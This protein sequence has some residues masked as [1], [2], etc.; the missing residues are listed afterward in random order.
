M[1]T[2]N[3]ELSHSLRLNSESCPIASMFPLATSIKVEKNISL[4]MTYSM[5]K[6]IGALK[7]QFICQMGTS[8]TS[9]HV[10][11]MTLDQFKE[12]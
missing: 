11:K 7:I 5:L 9:V 12:S 2:V 3:K 4:F 6:L 10:S 1:F 8:L